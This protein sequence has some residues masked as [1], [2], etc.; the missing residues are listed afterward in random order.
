MEYKYKIIIVNSK[1]RWI[2]IKSND[3]WDSYE[4]DA[5]FSFVEIIRNDTGGI[6]ESIGDGR[7]VIKNNDP[8]F[9]YQWD[10]LFGI[11]VIYPENMSEDEAI[12]YLSK[13]MS[14]FWFIHVPAEKRSGITNFQK[15]II[16]RGYDTR[17]IFL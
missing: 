2:F 11:V 13:Y 15:R 1:D 17:G 16:P 3:E 5:F 12:R 14:D 7:V 10:D 8:V 4:T 6:I 9:I